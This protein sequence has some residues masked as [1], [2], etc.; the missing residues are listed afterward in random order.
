M[1]S[2]HAEPT[3]MRLPFVKTAALVAAALFGAAAGIGILGVDQSGPMALLCAAAGVVAMIVAALTPE[4][5]PRPADPNAPPPAGGGAAPGQVSIEAL[6]YP[7]VII[8]AARRVALA[9]AEA[10]ALLGERILGA[11]VRIALRHP[12]ILDAEA[13]VREGGPPPV[14]EIHGFLRPESVYRLRAAAL[15]DDRVLLGFVDVT[16]ARLAER[17][18]VDFVANAS[19]ELRTPLATLLGFIETLQ[20][21]AAGDEPARQRFLEIMEREARRMSR[22]IDDLLSLSRIELD[23]FVPP[24]GVVELGPAVNDVA[25]ALAPRLDRDRRLLDVEIPPALPPVVGDRDQIMQVLHN[26]ISNALKYG[27]PATPIRLRAEPLARTPRGGQPMVRVCVEDEGDGIAPE[28]LPRLTERFYRVDTSRSRAVGG[29]GLGLAIVK[30]IVERH[31]GEL[32]IT[33]RL[34]AGSVVSFT[35][36]ASLVAEDEDE[37]R[38]GPSRDAV[39]EAAAS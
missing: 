11:D 36:P 14:E 30:H 18:R 20:G 33:S 26:L 15:D 4:P 32:S 37:E 7:V 8:D 24:R 17:M 22:L 6:A 19:H 9:N 31:R 3:A 28:H 39:R 2:A 12:A 35:L 38:D 27:R 25:R 21:P 13:S 34:G 23:K 5:T 16:Q 10:R 29:T 1:T